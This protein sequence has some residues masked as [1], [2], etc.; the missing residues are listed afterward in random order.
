MRTILHS[1]F[2][3][4]KWTE[5]GLEN[6]SAAVKEYLELKTELNEKLKFEKMGLVISKKCPFLAG[7]PDG[8]LTDMNRKSGLIEIKNVLYN[9][10]VSLTHA[11]S[12]KQR[13]TSA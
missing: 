12:L 4:T 9:K 8:K 13:K 10:P 5:I 7:S 6:E 1:K 3:G 2:K 11:A